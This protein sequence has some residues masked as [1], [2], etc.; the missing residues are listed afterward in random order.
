[1]ALKLFRWE[2][3]T[4]GRILYATGGTLPPIA[5]AMSATGVARSRH[6]T[7]PSPQDGDPR[8]MSFAQLPA[9]RAE[10]AALLL[11]EPQCGLVA[12]RDRPAGRTQIDQAV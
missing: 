3:A 7:P 2:Y 1:M 8:E 6:M 4:G 9:S 11:E 10:R 12:E 5:H